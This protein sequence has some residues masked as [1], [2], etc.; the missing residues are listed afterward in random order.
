MEKFRKYIPV[1]IPLWVIPVLFGGV[2]VIV[3]FYWEMLVLLIAFAT[4]SFVLLPLIST[5]YGC[6]HCPQRDTCPWMR[7]K[8]HTEQ[9]GD[10]VDRNSM[11][12]EGRR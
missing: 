11:V 3:D 7:H 8:K 1:I 10:D 5:K 6:A 2:I 12:R 9:V 4:N